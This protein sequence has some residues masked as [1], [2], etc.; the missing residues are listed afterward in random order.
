MSTRDSPHPSGD[1][2]KLRSAKR[3]PDLEMQ[4]ASEGFT[5]VPA[6][7]DKTTHSLLDNINMRAVSVLICAALCG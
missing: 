5:F 2:R 6:L 7:Q 3:L 4:E 1:P